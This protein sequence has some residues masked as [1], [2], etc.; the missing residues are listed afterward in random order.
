MDSCA[1]YLEVSRTSLLLIV[2]S[3]RRL[4]MWFTCI[5]LLILKFAFTESKVFS[6]CLINPI[7]REMM[8]DDGLMTT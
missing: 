4:T 7:V 5:K 3:T 8:H 1:D 6:L 2:S